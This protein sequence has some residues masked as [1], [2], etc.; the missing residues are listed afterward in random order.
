MLGSPRIE[1]EH[2]L[3]GLFREDKPLATH[4][5]PAH[6]SLESI[7]KQIEQHAPA[8]ERG[9]TSVDL[10]MSQRCRRAL[11]Y[12]AEEADQLSHR[13][14]GTDHFLLGLLRDE[15]SFAAQTLHQFGISLDAVRQY[16][17]AKSK[18]PP[19]IEEEALDLKLRSL[20]DANR[21]VWPR[22]IDIR[23]SAEKIDAQSRPPSPALSR[24]LMWKGTPGIE[25]IIKALTR[26]P[27]DR[28]LEEVSRSTESE[29]P[30]L[31]ADNDNL[32]EITQ[33]RDAV[34][35]LR[36][37]AKA[38][39]RESESPVTTCEADILRYCV[40]LCGRVIGGRSR[41]LTERD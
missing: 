5:L 39:D 1:A 35:G 29:V 21:K 8:R 34:R 26:R 40:L 9:A 24:R 22:E 32:R 19:P 3:L 4:F 28:E 11:T 17:K 6:G 36:R 2:L 20:V 25:A 10:P 16:A 12:A 31:I 33:V 15:E 13:L 23:P 37:E 38:L 27:K 30:D 14:I 41:E 7:R 18:E